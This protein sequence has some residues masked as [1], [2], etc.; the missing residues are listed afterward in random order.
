MVY[1]LISLPLHKRLS[2][3][4]SWLA[5]ALFCVFML[6]ARLLKDRV[7]SSDRGSGL[8]AQGSGWLLTPERTRTLSPEP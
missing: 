3:G 4:Q 1:G 7:V 2:W 5:L 8:G 6:C